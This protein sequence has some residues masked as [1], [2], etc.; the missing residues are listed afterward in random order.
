MYNLVKNL[1]RAI[2]GIQPDCRVI[3]RT[4]MILGFA[5]QI[6]RCEKSDVVAAEI[7][8]SPMVPTLPVGGQFTP[9]ISLS[10]RPQSLFL[11]CISRIQ[12]LRPSLKA[13]IS[14][15][16]ILS[17]SITQLQWANV[18]SR[19]NRYEF[20]INGHRWPSTCWEP[21]SIE[22]ISW[23]NIIATSS[24]E[25]V[26]KQRCISQFIWATHCSMV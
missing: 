16:A 18:A 23:F 2:R 20:C 6:L 4:S 21:D 17:D 5:G 9:E 22:F 26:H 13:D 15:H 24:A 7:E 19:K 1:S 10:Q 8:G 11:Y 12:P 14:R 3:F 25:T